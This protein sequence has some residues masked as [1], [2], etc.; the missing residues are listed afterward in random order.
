MISIHLTD[1]CNN[2]CIFCIVD[3]PNQ[4]GEQVST[5]RIVSFLEENSGKGY[6]AVN[7]HGGEATTRRDFMNILQKIN[8]LNYPTIILQ[9]NARKLRNMEFA[10][11]VREQNVDLFVISV[12]GKDSQTLDFITQIPKS[13]E[14]CIQGI[15]NVKELGAK[16]RTN[17]VVSRLNYQELEEIVSLLL[18]LKVD[19]INISALH[20][21]GTAY[22]N[23]E[24]VTPTYAEI[25]PSLKKAVD[26]VVGHSVRLTLEGFPY[27]TIPGLEQ[28]MI[29]WSTER[30]KMLYHDMVFDDYEE[31]MDR[32]F[33]SKG[34][35]CIDCPHIKVC[36]GVY[37]EYIEKRGWDEFGVKSD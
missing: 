35:P 33:R 23:F 16:V 30:F 4:K 8:E 26:K 1:R 9:T 25:L 28:H 21:G 18:E 20:T 22:R 5:K 7:L 3:A 27:C 17:T 12:H 13:F 29:D 19:H 24:Q 36:G 32:E 14:Q 31:F 15:K 2:R 34:I 10:K 11:K 37:K 6:K